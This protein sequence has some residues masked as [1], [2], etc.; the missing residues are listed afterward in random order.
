MTRVICLLFM[1][2]GR[3]QMFI[4]PNGHASHRDYYFIIINAQALDLFSNVQHQWNRN[5]DLR[6]Y[7]IDHSLSIII[8]DYRFLRHVECLYVHVDKETLT[9]S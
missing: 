7:S 4:T 8:P 2:W 9:L 1:A 5:G 3:L 6:L